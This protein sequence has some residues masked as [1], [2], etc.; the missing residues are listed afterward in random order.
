MSTLYVYLD[1]RNPVICVLSLINSSHALL[2]PGATK[3]ECIF[4]RR[5]NNLGDCSRYFN[6]GPARREGTVKT[7][8]PSQVTLFRNNRLECK[9][10]FRFIFITR[11]PE[12]DRRSPYF[13]SSPHLERIRNKFRRE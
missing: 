10:I 12:R 1:H 13:F 3:P 5:V 11:V 6:V 7:H 4:S 8:M 2:L 9:D